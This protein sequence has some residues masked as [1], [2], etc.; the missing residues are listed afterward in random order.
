LPINATKSAINPTSLSEK[1][2]NPPWP[3]QGTTNSKNKLKLSFKWPP[4]RKKSNPAAKDPKTLK[5][6]IILAKNLVEGE[7]FDLPL[8]KEVGIAI[9][10]TDDK[11]ISFERLGLT[12]HSEMDLEHNGHKKGFHKLQTNLNMPLPLR[13]FE[14]PRTQP[15]D[16]SDSSFFMTHM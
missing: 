3:A 1:M 8:I 16:S 15:G 5:G 9:E 6:K 4:R 2:T 10:E 12:S 11:T 14:S 7:G 13:N